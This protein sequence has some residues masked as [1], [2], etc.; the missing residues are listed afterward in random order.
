M[1]P[2]FLDADTKNPGSCRGF[3]VCVLRHGRL[4]DFAFLVDHVLANNRVILL[5]FELVRHSTLV[6][7]RCIK[8]AGTRR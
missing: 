4:L 6:L 2:V 5:D 1:H 8:V 7:I 3:I